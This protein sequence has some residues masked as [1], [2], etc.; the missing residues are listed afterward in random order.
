MI[1][2]SGIIKLLELKKPRGSDNELLTYEADP[3][4][5]DIAIAG[6][7]EEIGNNTSIPQAQTTKPAT[8]AAGDN[9]VKIPNEY[10]GRMVV[11]E[12]SYNIGGN[13]VTEPLH[14]ISPTD[15]SNINAGLQGYTTDKL[16]YYSIS[17]RYI[18]VGP[19][20]CLTGGTISMTW[21][22]PLTLEDID[23]MP[24]HMTIYYGARANM[25][26]EVVNLP[27]YEGVR[28]TFVKKMLSS[29]VAYEPAQEQVRERA[30]PDQVLRDMAEME[31]LG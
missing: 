12:Y 19:H 29:A 9:Q 20:K 18:T 7:I 10:T 15:M 6:A 25:I 17:G 24:D 26:D 5:F 23:N 28:R 27:L 1:G 4:I 31:D 16:K 11:V 3:E 14:P 22:R 13:T 30:M 2:M 8:L 21:Q